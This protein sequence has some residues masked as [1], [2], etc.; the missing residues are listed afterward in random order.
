MWSF[1][2]RVANWV[3]H[4]FGPLSIR[5]KP[6][7]IMRFCEESIE[8]AQACEMTKQEV[9]MMVEYVY[10]KNPGEVKQEIGGVMTTLAALCS[11]HDLNLQ[12]IGDKS[13]QDCW[14]RVDEI[15]RKNL[16]MP[17]FSRKV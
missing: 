13:L 11:S 16:N 15:R 5:N 3:L 12:E 8:L 10:S 17:R 1:Q 2:I 9:I 14:E 7:R 4:C 6:E